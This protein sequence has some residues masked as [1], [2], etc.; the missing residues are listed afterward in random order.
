[1]LATITGNGLKVYLKLLLCS[2]LENLIKKAMKQ[3][4][5]NV[6]HNRKSTITVPFYARIG[7]VFFECFEPVCQIWLVSILFMYLEY[8]RKWLGGDNSP[9]PSRIP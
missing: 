2:F 6:Q 3:F 1:M 5:S 7:P 4:I 8:H 9:S